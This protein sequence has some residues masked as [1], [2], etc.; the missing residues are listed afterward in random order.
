MSFIS[1]TSLR[2]VVE[3]SRLNGLSTTAHLMSSRNRPRNSGDKGPEK[4][5]MKNVMK[6]ANK[7]SD[8]EGT[9]RTA[10]MEALKA[11][12]SGQNL[13]QDKQAQEDKL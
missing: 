6:K 5:Y 3:C 8:T 7:N 11:I 13:P 10:F 12:E 2:R 9:A 4:N 1:V